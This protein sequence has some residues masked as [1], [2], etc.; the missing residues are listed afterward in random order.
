M[1]QNEEARVWVNRIAAFLTGAVVMLAVMSFVVITPLKDKNA[2]LTAQLDEIRNGAVR[3]L[4][5]AT[6]QFQNGSYENAKRTLDVLFKEQPTSAE[7]AE[8]KKLYTEIEAVVT[9]MD[10]AW[11]SA[12]AEV[13][14]AWEETRTAE[15]RAKLEQER[16]LLEINLE[17]TLNTEW[18]RSRQEIRRE[19]EQGTM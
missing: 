2:T 8:G 18:E 6:V 1:I 19:W 14:A 3:L 10:Q 9:K 13:R 12:S 17:D 16:V 5:E 11:E 7:A 15:L 4:G